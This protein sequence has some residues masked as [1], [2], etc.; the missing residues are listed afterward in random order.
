M[1]GLKLPKWPT[2][3]EWRHKNDDVY[4][5]EYEVQVKLTVK[6]I[7]GKAVRQRTARFARW[8]GLQGHDGMMGP[9]GDVGPQGEKGKDGKLDAESL[10]HLLHN[11]PDVKRAVLAL[12]G[13]SNS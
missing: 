3:T 9:M 6:E 10:I 7:V 8:A 1:F 2:K 11:D 13:H 5:E 4:D 12:M